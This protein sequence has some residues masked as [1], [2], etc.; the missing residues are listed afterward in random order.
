MTMRQ[1]PDVSHRTNLPE[2]VLRVQRLFRPGSGAETPAY[3]AAMSE[4]PGTRRSHGTVGP[5]DAFHAARRC[6]LAGERLDMRAIAHKLG[7]SRATLY[8]WSGPR[9]QLL[10][11]VIWSVAVEKY[12]E[13]GRA[14]RGRG[15]RRILDAFDRCLRAFARSPEL[16]RFL[17][18]DPEVALRVLTARDGPV[19]GRMVDAVAR[20]IRREVERG[21][22]RPP[23]D[24]HVL[25]HAVVRIGEA[26]LYNDSI[27]ALEPN[28]DAARAILGLLLR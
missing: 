27:V 21:D 6:Y 3:R 9:E 10:G 13:A 2:G 26:F 28:V 1:I 15:A 8:R 17:E 22:Y 19:Q 11:D 23:V 5:A 4:A 14:A 25:A 20:A 12:R 16:R 7:V 18:I 24:P